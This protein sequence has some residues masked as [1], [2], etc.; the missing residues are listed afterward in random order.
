MKKSSILIA[1]FAV[2]AAA[3]AAKAEA[4]IDFDG[5]FKPQSMH[6]IFTN[7]H[8][9]VSAE[10]LDAVTPVPSPSKFMIKPNAVCS[11]VCYPGNPG[12]IGNQPGDCGSQPAIYTSCPQEEVFPD[13]P[14][15]SGS[16]DGHP[17]PDTLQTW[18][19]YIV[20][21]ASLLKEA[22]NS[23]TARKS[24]QLARSYDQ[25]AARELVG[26]YM[27]QEKIKDVVSGYY[28]ANGNYEAAASLAGKGVRVAAGNGMV[29]INRSG[30]Q[31]QIA[32]H[33]LVAK[34][35]AIVHPNGKEKILPFIAGATFVATCMSSDNCWNAVGDGVS[36]A[37]EA[38][39]QIYYT[40]L[41]PGPAP[42][43]TW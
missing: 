40:W 25:A 32:D 14:M 29:F 28:T 33:H 24:L 11:I 39:S 26:Y 42:E 20:G 9:L 34:V 23:A 2:I 21:E 37:S 8:P 7:S 6:D 36:S 35:E 41:N 38:A 16:L 19:P 13:F 22:A 10:A 1:M 31:E 15:P 30:S 3:T 18:W 27:A 43:V 5:K 12:L 4:T 17:V